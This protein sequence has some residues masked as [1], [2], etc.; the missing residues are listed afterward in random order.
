MTPRLTT[1]VKR[2]AELRTAGL[3]EC[4]YTEEFT[5]R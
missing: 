2:V 5:L 3:H 4:H 1:L